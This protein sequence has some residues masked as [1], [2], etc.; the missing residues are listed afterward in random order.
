MWGIIKKGSWEQVAVPQCCSAAIMQEPKIIIII[1]RLVLFS[2]T[3]Q[4]KEQFC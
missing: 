4:T 1:Y 2:F 3:P